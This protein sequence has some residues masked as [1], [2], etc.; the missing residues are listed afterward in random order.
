[1]KNKSTCFVEQEIARFT[2]SNRYYLTGPARF[3]EGIFMVWWPNSKHYVLTNQRI[4]ISVGVLSRKVDEV[5]LYRIKDVLYS[6]SLFERLWSIGN[7]TLVS[8]QVSD[9]HSTIKYIKNAE[10]VREL[11]RQHVQIARRRGRIREVDYFQ[12]PSGTYETDL[13]DL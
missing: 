7:I 1:M 5:E 10:Q 8:T 4:K 2:F 13:I 12:D 11:I 9:R 6:A 3:I